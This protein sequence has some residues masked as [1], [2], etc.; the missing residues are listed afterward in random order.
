MAIQKHLQFYRNTIISS[1]NSINFDLRGT[2]AAAAK[3]GGL[4]DGAPII[5][6]W[7]DH[8]DPNGADYNIDIYFEH[9]AL[10]I[11][12]T[13]GTEEHIDIMSIDTNFQTLLSLINK[14]TAILQTNLVNVQKTI[15]TSIKAAIDALDS[16]ISADAGSFLTSVTITDGKLTDKTQSDT[17]KAEKV[18]VADTDNHFTAENVEGALAEL[19][20]TITNNKTGGAVTVTADSTNT[21]YAMVYTISQGGKALSPQINIPKDQFL[22]TASFIASATDDDVTAAQAAGQTIIKGKPY[23]LLTFETTLEHVTPTYIDVSKLI[24]TYTSGS[25][26]TDK[27]QITIDPSTDGTSKIAA[28]IKTGSIEKTD[29]VSA[30]QTSLGKADTA[31]QTLSV[32]GQDGHVTD[33]TASVTINGADVSLTG[34]TATAV[35]TVADASPAATDTVNQ[36]ISKLYAGIQAAAQAAAI[37]SSTIKMNTETKK[38][39][40]NIDSSSIVS[41]LNN[42][43]A[44]TVG[45]VDCGTYNQ[46]PNPFIY[47]EA[48]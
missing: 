6:R 20:T 11:Y 27:V 25:V 19:F 37:D 46:D 33:N 14:N 8:Y 21:A 36:A 32:N 39:Y 16:T 45:V 29:L 2:M 30:V 31:I 5:Y 34:Y 41:D 4:G 10:G 43:G 9:C 26:E 15:D 7:K 40:V 18:T 23:L 17:I 42:G 48:H 12:H 24:D 28:S 1:I 44:L 13:A 35:T 38:L 22:K 47:E 3:A